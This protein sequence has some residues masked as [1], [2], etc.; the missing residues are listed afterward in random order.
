MDF[1]KIDHKIESS[2]LENFDYP[3]RKVGVIV[4]IFDEKK[5]FCFNK[6]G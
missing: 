2:D 1:Y 5:E 3:N 4:H 6:E